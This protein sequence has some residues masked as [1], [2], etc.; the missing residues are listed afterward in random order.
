MTQIVISLDIE[1]EKDRQQ[2]NLTLNTAGKGVT[3]SE[4][5]LNPQVSIRMAEGEPPLVVFNPV[6]N[7]NS[8]PFPSYVAR[9][10]EGDAIEATTPGIDTYPLKM[11]D[12]FTFLEVPNA[13]TYRK[14][15]AT[16]VSVQY[17]ADIIP[18]SDLS[19]EQMQI[20]TK[21]KGTL[22]SNWTSNYKIVDGVLII[23]I[24]G[25]FKT[26]S[27]RIYLFDVI[28]DPD[29]NCLIVSKQDEAT[30]QMLVD[31]ISRLFNK[32]GMRIFPA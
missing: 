7:P 4:Y 31:Q 22:I 16:V 2:Y 18:Y 21:I 24:Y 20:V 13:A 12:K 17:K 27:D 14:V 3:L 23:S 32:T 26:L 8:S 15:F 29:K 25:G 1:T 6:I 9:F 19:E 11:G 5:H 30:P 10:H 28:H